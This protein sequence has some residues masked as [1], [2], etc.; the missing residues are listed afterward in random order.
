MNASAPSLRGA[1]C[2]AS[3]RDTSAHKPRAAPT[4]KRTATKNPNFRNGF[5]W[6]E[7]RPARG[8][9]QCREGGFATPASASDCRSSASARIGRGTAASRLVQATMP[10]GD[11][12]NLTTRAQELFTWPHLSPPQQNP[13]PRRERRAPKLAPKTAPIFLQPN[14]I[15]IFVGQI[16]GKI[17]GVR[18]AG[19]FGENLGAQMRA[20]RTIP[21]K[22][23]HVRAGRGPAA[24]L[25]R[26]RAKSRF[27][28]PRKNRKNSRLHPRSS[29]H[30]TICQPTS[31]LAQPQSH[32]ELLNVTCRS[33]IMVLA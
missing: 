28:A 21:N 32:N 4:S 24:R 29:P 22:T 2:Q 3:Q 20:P 9:G 1:F 33:R 6:R 14:L 26:R 17:L 23:P 16:L 10:K 7:A 12:Q 25:T 31:A 11:V 8:R 27:G 19:D 13:G 5:F 30:A 18:R 15:E